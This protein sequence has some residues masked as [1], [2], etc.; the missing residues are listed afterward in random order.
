MKR[1]GVLLL[2][3]W[4]TSLCACVAPQ[5]QLRTEQDMAEMK[6]RLAEVERRTSGVGEEG[7]LGTMDRLAESGRRLAETQASLDAL[8]V[9]FQ[10]VNGRL[11]DQDTDLQRLRDELALI[12]EDLNLRIEALEL[13]LNELSAKPT[14]TS[15]P[16]ANN[17]SK[18]QSPEEIYTR[19]LA[20]VREGKDMQAA[21]EGFQAFLK[22]YPQHSLAINAEYWIGETYYGDKQYK[23][24][25]LQF[26]EIIDKNPQH[27][28]VPSALLKQA[29][30]FQGLG[31]HENARLLLEKVVA[32]YPQSPEAGKAQQ[33]LK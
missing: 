31:D 4:L 33:K 21:R 12:R 11:A 8:R 6:R 32:S 20:L 3:L 19:S 14:T 15:A 23:N 27:V 18:A 22:D 9:E 13:R 30:A 7:L 1:L 26:Q 28:K 29:L 5:S 25:I 10:T 2:S 17:T 24:A 16:Q